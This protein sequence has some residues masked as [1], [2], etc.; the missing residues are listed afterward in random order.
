MLTPKPYAEDGAPGR[1]S[2]PGN[3]R[4]PPG[5]DG[6]EHP[7]EIDEI[8]NAAHDAAT[9][10]IPGDEEGD[11]GEDFNE[12]PSNKKFLEMV[13]E[14]ESQAQFY[15]NQINRRAWERAY[16]A[17]RQQHFD[18]SKY[19]TT[20]FKNRSRL[21]IPK[22]RSAVRKDLAATRASLFGSLDAIS[23]MPGNESDPHQRASAAVIQE[24][25]N[26][27]TDRS[28]NKASIPWFHVAIGARQTS[29][30]T[31]FCVSKQS[32]KLELKRQGTE[33]VSGEDGDRERDVWVPYIDRPDCQLIPP[34]N[35]VIDPAAD[36]TNPAQDSAYF[37]IKWPMRIDEIKRKQ[38]DPRKPWN[39]IPDQVLKSAGEGALMQAAAIRR[40][41]EQGIDR[42][43]E[44]QAGENFDII[45]VWETFMR[46]AGEDWT[47]ISIG[48]KHLLTDPAPVEEVYPE[49]FGERPITF[50]YGSFEAFCVFPQAAVESWQM[51]QQEANDVRNLTLDSFK[52]N[53][54]P[55]TKVVRGRQIDLD[56]LKRRGQ[57]T[58]IMVNKADDVTWERPPDVPSSADKIKQQL[59]IDFDD[60]AGQQ[61]YGTVQDNN[62]LGKTLGG[63]KLAAG[64]ANAVQEFDIA[65]WVETWAENVLNQIVRLEQYY[66][67]D[68]T[69][70]GLCGERAQ[71]M[72]KHGVNE[73]T[74][75]LLENNV[76]IRVNIGFG[77]GDPQQRLAKFQSA[78]QVALPM[79][80]LD[81]RFKSGEFSVDAEEVFQEVFGGAGY[82]DGGKR[83]I[84][85]GQ[86]QPNAG[87]DA[88]ADKLKSEAEKNRSQAKKNI[89]DALSNAAKVGIDV[90]QLELAVAAHKFDVDTGHMEQLGKA[91]DMGHQHGRDI[92]DR[93]MAAQGLNPDGTP[94]L[95]PGQEMGGEMGAAPA[96]T[97]AGGDPAAA[98][99][100]AEG[101]GAGNA[102]VDPAALGGHGVPASDA[103]H[104]QAQDNA[105]VQGKLDRATK[106]RTVKITGRG[107]D[108]RANQFQISE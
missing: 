108:G 41:R 88:A 45:W 89:L 72:E 10:D 56:Q 4:P 104:Q 77:S 62:A 61:N 9:G 73:I 21:F 14:A 64:A 96:P 76:T 63:L 3:G 40:A 107:P 50:G 18:G 78:S 33:T 15:S 75:E 52:Q 105:E 58:A 35:C 87:A 85:K 42:Y 7:V 82:R 34:E 80:Q 60:L 70:L 94:I 54:M 55:V 81:P 95:P 31:G 99:L 92:A 97:E 44:S 103:G 13:R 22:T 74:D 38:R 1:K 28:N 91:R 46:T 59:D 86:P 26:Y 16:K 37:I 48:D 49:Q 47:F 30:F 19:T 29:L 98:A 8:E 106:P 20:D 71:L 66:E 24:L 43:D 57:G 90:Q 51:L 6:V 36:W 25:L 84:K 2:S 102:G 32:W 67:S 11:D 39:K 17:Y 100:G 53:V 12:K 23:A 27:R 83:F 68:E 101:P 79:A 5:E 93:K 69:V 65:V